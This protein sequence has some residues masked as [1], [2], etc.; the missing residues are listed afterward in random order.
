MSMF[1]DLIPAPRNSGGGMFDDLI[2]VKTA[3]PDGYFATQGQMAREGFDQATRGVG[4]LSEAARFAVS[5]AGRNAVQDTPANRV[6]GGFSALDPS[7][8]Q[9]PLTE[10]E[11]SAANR[12]N[13]G[14]VVKGFGNTVAGGLSYLTSPINAALRTYAGEPIEKATGIPKEY[15]EFAL[16]LAVPAKGPPKL[17]QR[18]PTPSPGQSVTEAANRIGV[19]VPRAVSTDSMVAQRTAAT[20]RNVPGAGDPIIKATERTINQLGQRADDVTQALGSGGV[21]ASGDAASTAIQRWITGTSKAN[22]EKLYK[23]VDDLV[24]P[25]ITT[26]LVNTQRAASDIKGLREL[27]ALPDESGAVSR[28][29]RAL[30]RPEG[31]TYEGVKT[32]RTSIGEMLDNK[33][34]PAN[35]SEG[36][37]RSLYKALSSDLRLSVQRGGGDAAVSAFER[38]NRYFALASNRREALA[39]IVG[40]DGNAPAEQVFDRLASMAGSGSRADIA[41]LAQARK[42]IGPEDWN[43]FVS[44]VVA[45]MGRDPAARGAPEALQ[46]ADFSPQ[47]FMTA[48]GKLSPEGRSVLFRSTGRGDLASVLDDIAAVSTRFKEL[49]KFSNPSGTGQTLSGAGLGAGLFADP[50]TAISLVIGGRGIA[51]MLSRPA[52]AASV[53]DWSKSYSQLVRSPTPANV[54]R[55]NL[56]STNL[57]NNLGPQFGTF[58]PADFLRAIQGPVRAPAEQEQGQPERVVN[59]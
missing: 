58:T 55:V 26:P 7:G 38:A 30:E 17:P 48:Y 15:T 10:S 6:A 43:E 12:E 14:N 50:V 40:K 36:E 25:T 44:G 54:A 46:A 33:M 9:A 13:A 53:R 39:K 56:A 35:I 51:Y 3:K 19:D 41:K 47:R 42:A 28:V 34:L 32:L 57:I 1:D 59:Q 52:Q 16:S 29:A 22:A 23:R 24:N 37:L 18:I 49:Q 20:V 8:P 2:P 11:L 27:A 5:G 4:Q 45:K 31:L 21:Q